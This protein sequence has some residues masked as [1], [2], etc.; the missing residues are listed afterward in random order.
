MVRR[1]S[2]VKG[3]GIGQ[4]PNENERDNR[5]VSKR[6][7]N[8]LR[9]LSP[10]LQHDLAS[11][12][13]TQILSSQSSLWD[14]RMHGILRTVSAILSSSPQ[15]NLP[16]DGIAFSNDNSNFDDDHAQLLLCSLNT[17]THGTTEEQGSEVSLDVSSRRLLNWKEW[18]DAKFKQL[19]LMAKQDMYGIPVPAPRDAIVLRHHWNYAIK[20]DGTQKARNCCNGS[21]AAPQLKLANTYSSCIKQPCMC[22]FFALCAR[23]GYISLKVDAMNVY[24]NSPP[25]NQPTFVVIDDQYTDWLVSRS[26]WCCRLV[27]WCSLFRTLP[28]TSRIRCSLG[29][30]CQPVIAQRGFTS[31]THK[32]SLYQGTYKGHRM[33]ICHQVDDLAIGCANIDA[34]K[35]LA[36]IICTK[37]GIDLRDKPILDSFNGV[38]V[39]QRDRYIKITCETYIDKLLAH[40]GW[41]SSGSRETDK[42]P[43]EPLA[44]STTQQMFDDYATAPRDR[45]AEYCDLEMAAGFSYQ[46]VLG[47]LIYAY[48]VA[49]PDIGYAVTTLARISD[50]R[51]RCTTTPCAVSHVPTYDKNW[52]LLYWRNAL[53]VTSARLATSRLSPGSVPPDYPQV[54]SSTE[55]AGYLDAAHATD[56]CHASFDH[57]ACSCSAVALWLTSRRSNGPFPPAPLKQRSCR[58]PCCQD[59]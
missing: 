28:R 46:S 8:T 24:A 12:G 38:D 32:C 55:L 41:S 40:Y 1:L 6:R 16:D 52:G 13:G 49:R 23:E 5:L 15:S 18:Q 22:L 51:Q 39:D 33:L 31:T 14:I 42:K 30:V 58:C 29:K 2:K 25:L 26:S 7:S 54:Q 3:V 11:C 4:V 20:G 17:T 36:C 21:L 10:N 53:L 57:W 9:P 34:I 37:D 47:A 45:T 50:H 56:L 35:D 59:C 27:K 19:D 48:A 44:A 43:T